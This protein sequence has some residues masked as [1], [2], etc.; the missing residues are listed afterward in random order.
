MNRSG[1]GFGK[2]EEGSVS[3]LYSMHAICETFL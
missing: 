1:L 2:L 3:N